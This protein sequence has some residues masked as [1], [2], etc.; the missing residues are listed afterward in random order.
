MG[1]FIRTA[2]RMTKIAPTIPRSNDFPSPLTNHVSL[3]AVRSPCGSHSREYRPRARPFSLLTAFRTWQISFH[4]ILSVTHQEY[5]RVTSISNIKSKF[6]STPHDYVPD[7]YYI[8]PKFNT[9]KPLN[10]RRANATMVMLARNS[11][12]DNAVRS[13][14]RIQD[15]FNSKFQY[16]W[17]FLNEE[18]FTD[19][20]KQ[21]VFVVRFVPS[22]LIWIQTYLQRH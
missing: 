12:L 8:P 7:K 18:P 3:R 14:R 10:V 9:S 20:F 4:F 1:G 13:V 19:E 11:D 17:V 22:S 6:T 16:P 15:R 2:Q 5:G 21:W